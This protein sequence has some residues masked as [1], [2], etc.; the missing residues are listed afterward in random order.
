[1][2]RNIFNTA[3][4]IGAGMTTLGASESLAIIGAISGIGLMTCNPVLAF[5]AAAAFTG[6][7]VASYKVGKEKLGLNLS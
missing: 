4:S 7:I 5:G 1:M 2:L 6:G 3:S